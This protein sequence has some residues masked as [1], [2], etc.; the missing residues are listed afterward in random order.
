LFKNEYIVAAQLEYLKPTLGNDF[1]DEV[2]AGTWDSDDVMT[3]IKNCMY[4]YAGAMSIAF[5]FAQL[6]SKG[7]FVNNDDYSRAVTSQELALIKKSLLE[8]GDAYK[9]E[10]VRFLYDNQ[11][12]YDEYEIAT[13][14]QQRT[15]GFVV[16]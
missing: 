1:Y 13:T 2:V 14:Y 16:D 3:Y 4:Y 10:L 8:V 12:D 9:K 11:D 7:L 6:G 5:L 15:G